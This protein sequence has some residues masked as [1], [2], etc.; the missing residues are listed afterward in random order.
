MKEYIMVA[1]LV[2]LVSASTVKACGLMMVLTAFATP[3]VGVDIN[4]LPE[5]DPGSMVSA[6]TLLFGGLLL[7]SSK[8]R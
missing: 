4:F 1:R 2:R 6:V 7:L 8:R 3:A 5:I